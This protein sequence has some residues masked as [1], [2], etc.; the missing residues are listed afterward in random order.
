M[1]F[2]SFHF[3][4]MEWY[5]I[6]FYIGKRHKCFR[7]RKIEGIQTQNSTFWSSSGRNLFCWV[8]MRIFMCNPKING[9]EL[10]NTGIPYPLLPE[11]GG[12]IWC[13][14]LRQGRAART[15]PCPGSSWPARRC[16]PAGPCGSA[17]QSELSCSCRCT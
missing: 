6:F 13:R 5:R 2:F 14:V 16:S 10:S 11:E 8:H 1:T 4:V 3:S 17:V 15:P 12:P 7:E 9:N